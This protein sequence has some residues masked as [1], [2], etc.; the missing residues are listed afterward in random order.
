MENGKAQTY[1]DDPN[2]QAFKEMCK[3]Y[4]EDRIITIVYNTKDFCICNMANQC[5][6]LFI[7]P[8]SHELTMLTKQYKAYC[9]ITI[10]PDQAMTIVND[11]SYIANFGNLD[12]TTWNKR[13]F[14]LN[15]K[16]Y[17]WFKNIKDKNMQQGPTSD[18][19]FNMETYFHR[20]MKTN[21]KL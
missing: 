12:R 19:D 3:R 10:T 4:F 16:N 9:G 5:Y 6:A 1:T 20:L 7:Y 13:T 14:L 8:R 11:P 21:S 2:T 15:D 18:I 17:D